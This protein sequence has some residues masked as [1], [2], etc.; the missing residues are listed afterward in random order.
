MARTLKGTLTLC[1]AMGLASIALG[2]QG[3]PPRPSALGPFLS[4]PDVQKELKLSNEQI[5]KLKD[6]LGK[7]QDKYKDF[8]TKAQ[9]LSQDEVQK[10][11]KAMNEDSQKAMAGVLDAKQMKRFK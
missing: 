4:N 10:Q 3:Q 11:F 8:F 7:V 1:L 2:Q 6:A 5:D 9:Q